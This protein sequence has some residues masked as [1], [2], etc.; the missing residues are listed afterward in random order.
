MPIHLHYDKSLKL[1]YYQY[2]NQ[3]KYYFDINNVQSLI[4]AYKRALK[5][6]RAIQWSQHNYR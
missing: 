4:K 3:H 6:S 5:Q 1:Y 2:G